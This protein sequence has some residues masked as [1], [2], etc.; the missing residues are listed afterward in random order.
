MKLAQGKSV[1]PVAAAVAAAD[2]MVDSTEEVEAAA[3]D[4]R[5]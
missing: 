4:T 1:D 2:V 5:I 3:D